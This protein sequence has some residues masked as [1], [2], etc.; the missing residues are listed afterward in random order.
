MKLAVNIIGTEDGV[1][2]QGTC[3][4]LELL[5]HEAVCVGSRA[6]SQ[7]ISALQ[8]SSIAAVLDLAGAL[9]CASCVNRWCMDFGMV[10]TFRVSLFRVLDRVN[11]HGAFFSY[12]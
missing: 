9:V 5:V 10:M 2:G 3:F 4:V 12:L 6:L 1:R 8:E 7:S 11:L